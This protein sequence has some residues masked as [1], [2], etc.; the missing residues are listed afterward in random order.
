MTVAPVLDVRHALADAGFRFG[1]R[2]PLTFTDDELDDAIVDLTCTVG[3]LQHTAARALPPADYFAA[4]AEA[5]RDVA[6]FVPDRG[7]R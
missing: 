7:P 4:V 5:I 1:G 6:A 3:A 2:D